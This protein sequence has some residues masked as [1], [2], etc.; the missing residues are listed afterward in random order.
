MLADIKQG[1]KMKNSTR[2]ELI[3]NASLLGLMGL[4]GCTLNGDSFVN[5][6]VPEDAKLPPWVADTLADQESPGIYATGKVPEDQS[7]NKKKS[8]DCPP[9]TAIPNI[10]RST[11]GPERKLPFTDGTSTIS[12]NTIKLDQEILGHINKRRRAYA[13]SSLKMDE[14]LSEIGREHSMTMVKGGMLEDPIVDR[15]ESKTMA[16]TVY[17]GLGKAGKN[18]RTRKI[19]S[20]DP[21][22]AAKAIFEEF[23]FIEESLQREVILNPNAK[24]GAVGSVYSDQSYWVTLYVVEGEVC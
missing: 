15:F 3:K 19:V 5:V 18:P 20:S 13:H 24:Y 1:N 6:E 23:M 17:M 22:E 4:A 16:A 14:R 8:K 2:R 12:T 11:P 7:K 21:E 10:Q 9:T